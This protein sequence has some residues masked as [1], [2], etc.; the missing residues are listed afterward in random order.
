MFHQNKKRSL[1][2]LWNHQSENPRAPKMLGTMTLQK[3]TILALVHQFIEVG[4]DE[5]K[6]NLAGWR[7]VHDG[8]K[9]ITVEISPKFVKKEATPIGP[10]PPIDDDE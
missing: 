9:Y 7:N 1:G 6:C 10:T 4:G 5:L 3:A 8:Q 2:A